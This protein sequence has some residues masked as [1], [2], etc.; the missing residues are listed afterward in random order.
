MP[1]HL[2]FLRAIARLQWATYP[3]LLF[4]AT[5]ITL[6]SFSQIALSLIPTLWWEH[7]PVDFLRNYPALDGL[8]R[9]DCEFFEQIARV[10]YSEPAL[11]N[12]FPLYPMVARTVHMLTKLPLPLA[13]ILVS[14]AAGLGAFLVIYRIFTILAE[15]GAAQWALALMAAY[16]FAFFQATAYPESLM[17]FCS[18][19]AILFALRGNHI[20]AGVA[21]GLGILAR[22]LTIFAGLALVAAQVRQRGW[23]PRRLLFSPA[24]LGLLIPWLFV[25]FY[26][27]VLWSKF[28]DALAFLT[29]RANWG[30]RAWWGVNQLLR[31]TERSVDVHVMY[32][33]LPFALL[34]S[35]GAVALVSR[36][37]WSELAAFAIGL[38]L[39]LW[40]VGVWGLGR[41]SA[42]CWPAFLPLG[43]W[44]S[45]QPKLQAPVIVLLAVF[46]GLFFYLFVH[47]FPIL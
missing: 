40:A 18:A 4:I 1:T 41:Y 47:Q 31:T 28:G 42:S 34:P 19:L 11:T 46:Q 37:Q 26:C 8:C 2:T 23:Q 6:L 43:V 29:A 27:L 7:R 14:N 35:I 33:Y 16:P 25:A 15:E 22:H 17:V 32:T 36:R 39:V 9:F 44:L 24:V 21:L 30:P 12:F 13:L 3:T 38:M 5:R 10:G 20:W 45:K